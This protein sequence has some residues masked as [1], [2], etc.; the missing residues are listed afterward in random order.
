MNKL[1]SRTFISF[2]FNFLSF[3]ILN[4][5]NKRKYF[6]RTILPAWDEPVREWWRLRDKFSKAIQ[7]EKNESAQTLEKRCRHLQFP[8][9]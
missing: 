7:L 2:L 6:K 8:D 1:S 9:H 5:S 4:D 3:V